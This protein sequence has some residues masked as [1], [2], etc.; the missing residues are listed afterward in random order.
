MPRLALPLLGGFQAR[1]GP[2][3]PLALPAKVQALLGCLACAPASPTPVT[4]SPG[5]QPFPSVTVF[6][7]P[8]VPTGLSGFCPVHRR[9]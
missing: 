8:L 4:S 7:E 6:Y 5:S 9:H 2:G 1:L 3:S